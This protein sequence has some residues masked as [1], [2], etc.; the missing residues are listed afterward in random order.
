MLFGSGSHR[1][2]WSVAAVCCFSPLTACSNERPASIESAGHRS[3]SESGDDTGRA[4]PYVAKDATICV[5]VTIDPTIVARH[6]PEMDSGATSGFGSELS[7]AFRNE[8]I[9]PRTHDGETRIIPVH[10]PMGLNA[11]CADAPPL[12]IEIRY[13]PLPGG[14]PART[15]TK[16][17]QNG[18]LILADRN[19]VQVHALSVPYKLSV[20][21]IHKGNETNRIISL[22]L[23]KIA[24]EKGS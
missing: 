13:V 14:G 23:D 10:G 21:D 6:F 3:I 22:I 15:D 5:S 12:L 19:D 16:V 8:G 20:F 18:R 2:F 4:K 7:E 9:D 1:L 24:F 11:P 17:F